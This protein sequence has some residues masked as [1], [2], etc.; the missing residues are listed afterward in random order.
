MYARRRFRDGHFDSSFSVVPATHYVMAVIASANLLCYCPGQLSS[1]YSSG[2]AG[3]YLESLSSVSSSRIRAQSFQSRQK[4]NP[5]KWN[6]PR[7][8]IQVEIVSDSSVLE[9]HEN[10]P[11][12]ADHHS[13]SVFEDE[14]NGICCYRTASGEVTCEGYD[15]GPHFHPAARCLQRTVVENAQ[16]MSFL[17][18]SNSLCSTSSLMPEVSIYKFVKDVPGQ[19]WCEGKDES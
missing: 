19:N 3:V 17:T 11:S 9:S 12:A 15:E 7:A 1:F 13:S 8:A 10:Q 14:T 6:V 16:N 2:S 18:R 5:S 4:V